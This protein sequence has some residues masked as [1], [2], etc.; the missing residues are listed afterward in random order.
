M[1]IAWGTEHAQAVARSV[2]VMAVRP[3][4]HG[5]RLSCLSYNSV[6]TGTQE[7]SITLQVT[8]ESIARETSVPSRQAFLMPKTSLS[9]PCP[10]L[11]GLVCEDPS[12]DSHLRLMHLPFSSPQCR[13][14]P[15][16]GIP[17]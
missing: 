7:R 17:V 12:L 9:V 4:D 3:E 2:L 1:S 11:P 6:S 8:C 5:A 15:G 14:H 10:H 13:H 16:I